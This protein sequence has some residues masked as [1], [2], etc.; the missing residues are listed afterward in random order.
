M[1]W[2]FVYILLSELDK[3][4]YIGFTPSDVFERFEKHQWGLVNSTKDRRPLKL[5]FFEAY[6]TQED[7]L[8]RE[9]YFKTTK[10]KTTLK[11]ML[12]AFFQI[13]K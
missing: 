8:R 7:A 11:S 6:L 5:I 9:R 1:K 3:K 13:H 10:G 12:K 4:L 2:Y